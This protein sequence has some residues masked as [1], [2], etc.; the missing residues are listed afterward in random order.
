MG[1]WDGRI[2]DDFEENYSSWENVNIWNEEISDVSKLYS[3]VSFFALKSAKVLNDEYSPLYTKID[4]LCWELKAQIDVSDNKQLKELFS[5][6]Q[7]ISTLK[8]RPS[9]TKIKENFWEDSEEYSIWIKFAEDLDNL[10][11]EYEFFLEELWRY[12]SSMQLIWPVIGHTAYNFEDFFH[13][14][15]YFE[16][17]FNDLREEFDSVVKLASE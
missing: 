17:K 4:F 5:K 14:C 12:I 16:E 8:L 11:W 10:T 7:D 1:I 3:S 2:I 9:T 15:D 6:I 13:A